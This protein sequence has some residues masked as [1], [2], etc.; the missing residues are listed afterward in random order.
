MAPSLFEQLGG[1][2]S[3]EAVVADF[4]ARIIADDA[5]KGIFAD[6]DMDQ[7][8]RHQ[9]RFIGYALGGPNQ[10]TGRNMQRAH[11]GVGIT[12]AQFVAVA[13]HLD[14]S[15]ASFDVPRHLIDQVIAHLAS[16]KDDVVE[17][18]PSATDGPERRAPVRRRRLLGA[19]RNR[20]C[21]T[22]PSV[23]AGSSRTRGER[24]D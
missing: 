9:A 22:S 21:E 2:S 17:R 10:F 18:W 3:I 6:I 19:R 13:G 14:A 8:R 1:S 20:A 7:L 5:L 16:L 24:R 11:R 12:E 15:L 23:A 4:Y